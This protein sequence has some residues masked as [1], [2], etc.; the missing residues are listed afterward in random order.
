M[1]ELYLSYAEQRRLHGVDNYCIPSRFIG[2]LPAELVEEVR[3]AVRVSRPAAAPSGRFRDEAPGGIA[4]GQ[5]VRH[6]QFGEGIVLNHEGHGNHAR[7]QVNF[8]HA[9]PKWLV[10]AY[11]RLEVM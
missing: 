4:L 10:L 3:P 9:G 8:E 1:R 11:A 5:R 2:E 6:G 7:V